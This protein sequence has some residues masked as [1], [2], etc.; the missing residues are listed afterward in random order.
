M[1]N[2]VFSKSLQQEKSIGIHKEILLIKIFIYLQVL[3]HENW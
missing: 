1:R 3:S 2:E